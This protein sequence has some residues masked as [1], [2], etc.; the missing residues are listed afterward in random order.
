[1]SLSVAQSLQSLALGQALMVA[2]ALGES[3]P[4]KTAATI[5]ALLL[6]LAQGM[7]ELPGRRVAARQ[8]LLALLGTAKVGDRALAADIR[9]ILAPDGTDTWVQ[10]DAILM[11]ALTEVHAWADAHDPALARRCRDWLAV[12]AAGERLAP[13]ALPA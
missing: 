5:A 9:Q 12:W 10:R 2:P 8:S 3:Y 7:E 13:P 4:G 6:V 11:G 1:M